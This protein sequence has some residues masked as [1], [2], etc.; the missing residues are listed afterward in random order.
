MS[1]Y[2]TKIRTDKGDLPI[3]YNALANLPTISNPNLLINSDFRKPVNQ[4]GKTSYTASS[5]RLYTIDRWS[6]GRGTL[7]IN[8]SSITFNGSSDTETGSRYLSQMWDK[9]LVGTHTV[10]FYSPSVVGEVYCIIRN[11]SDTSKDVTFIVS[12][13]YNKFSFDHPIGNFDTIFFRVGQGASIELSWIKLEAGDKMTTFVPRLYDEELLLCQRYY[14]R[15]GNETSSLYLPGFTHGENS[16]R[17]ALP[18]NLRAIPTINLSNC[19]IA[20][21]GS[22]WD[23]LSNSNI[24]NVYNENQYINVNIDP[25]GILDLN[26]IYYLVVASYMEFDA[27]IY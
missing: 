16:F 24:L 26:S 1:D 18:F 7:V 2:I 15:V 25:T 22:G 5:D 11:R 13:G 4:R 27:E 12:Q 21:A 3:D 23:A 6:I 14:V 10:S 19:H 8:Q 17:I 9:N 20:K